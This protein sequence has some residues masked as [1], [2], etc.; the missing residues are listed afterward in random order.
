MRGFFPRYYP[1]LLGGTR[2][3][4]WVLGAAQGYAASIDMNFAAGLYYGR[5][6]ADLTT[7]RASTAY[8]SNAAGVWSSFAINTPR[9]TDQGLLV[10]ESRTNSI[11]NSTMVGAS[12]PSTFPTNW[13]VNINGNVGTLAITVVGTGVED[14]I[15]YI[16]IQVAGL[17]TGAGFFQAVFDT[18]TAIT[19]ASGETWTNSIFLKLA[20]GSLTNVGTRTLG[21][22][23][24]TAAGGFVTNGGNTSVTPGSG[25][26]GSS[27]FSYTRTLSGGGTV[28]RTVS[29]F[30]FSY[31]AAAIDAT[32]RIGIPQLELGSFATSPIPTTTVAVTRAADVITLTMPPTFGSAFSLFASW[33][34]NGLAPAGSRQFAIIP[35]NV[36]LTS[37]ASI[38][39]FANSSNRAISRTIPTAGNSGIILFDP[40]PPVVGTTYKTA[41]AFSLDSLRGA[42]GG[43]LTTPDTVADVP[44]SLTTVGLGGTSTGVLQLNGYLKR[45]AIWPTT[46]IPNAAL[47]GTTTP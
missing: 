38:E 9:I 15:A 17:P 40:A 27:R 32:F 6:P 45:I 14:G 20:S 29:F 10:E 22:S 24:Y 18:T 46:A 8:A 44:T 31:S 21:I 30:S 42:V 1:L 47:Q 5:T 12:A 23:E 37:F 28:A 39:G 35:S 43:S 34:L 3:P 11:R 36:G 26:L 13:T 2:I 25:N 33:S 19:A 41:M 7:S 4:Y 16:D